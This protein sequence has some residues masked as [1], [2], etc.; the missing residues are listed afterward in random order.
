M[1]KLPSLFDSNPVG[2]WISLARDDDSQLVKVV[3]ILKNFHSRSLHEKIRP[4]IMG[5]YEN[6]FMSL[7]DI[8]VR[9]SGND[10]IE[11]VSAIEK[12]HNQ[13]D[14]NKIMTW[15]FLDD[16][17]NREY[18]KE[19]TFLKIFQAASVLT[20]LLAVV[21]II[22]LVSYNILSRTKEFGIRKILGAK[23]HHLL[24]IHGK[25]F[26]K[27]M[28]VSIFLAAPL[29]WYF[30]NTWLEDYAY[31]ISLTAW[32]LLVVISGVI[33]TIGIIVSLLAIR[34]AKRNP[35]ESLRYE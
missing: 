7:D 23:I 27:S 29:F 3:G 1:R 9:V 19:M 22:G 5:H 17:V 20:F 25:T 15:E 35:A 34:S 33:V 13:Y 8:L 4:V 6:P 16:M 14:Q 30:G 24:F 18:E 10:L 31:K 26:L 28:L 12:I 32:P 11:T 21:G 2:Q